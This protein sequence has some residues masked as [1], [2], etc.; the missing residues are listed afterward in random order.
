VRADAHPKRLEIVLFLDAVVDERK[1][2]V[3]I[4]DGELP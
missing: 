2:A 3:L 4:G 1:L